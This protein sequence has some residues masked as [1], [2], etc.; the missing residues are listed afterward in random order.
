MS[1]DRRGFLA[2]SAALGL[3][4]A[5]PI[6]AAATP[7]PSRS[8]LRAVKVAA[9]A[10]FTADWGSLTAGY[11]A[12]DWFRDA[13]FG[14]WAHWA[15]PSV[16]GIGDDWYA[17]NMY[18]QG[19]PTYD[20][21][22]KTYGHPADTGFMQIQN[23]WRAEHWDPAEL[24]DL[25]K[26]AGARYFMA[27]AN[28]HDNL[29]CYASTH[30]PWNATRIGP[31]RDIVGTWAKLARERGLRFAVSNHSAHAW[32]WN[33]IAYDYDPVGPRRGQRYDAATLTPG[34]GR[35]Q[36]WDGL[37]PQQLYTGASMA[38]PD[39]IGSLAEAGAW[40]AATDGLW[41]E[42]VPPDPEYA[43]RWALRC[44][45]LIDR[46]DPDM[47]Y[48]DNHDL[49]LQQTG[50]DIAAYFLNR[51]M[52]RRGGRLEGVVTA[53]ET[54]PQRRMGL[55]DVVERGQKSF[56][57]PYPW[58]T[59]TC[60][61]NWFYGEQYLRDNSYKT[62]AKVLH[63]LCDVVSKNGNMML[64]VPIRGDGTIDA[65]E[66]EIVETIG[67][68]MR[69][70]GA[71]IYATRPW[72]I[73]AEGKGEA[74]GGAFS[75]GGNDTSYTARD[76]R[77]VT[78]GKALQALVLGWPDDGVARL[79]LL[80]RD[81]PV[82]RGAVRRVSLPGDGE[83]LAFTRTADALEVRLPAAARDPIGL[84]LVIEGPGLVD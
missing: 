40:H 9:P 30:Q 19:H 26:A 77:Y 76:I 61:G 83:S 41:N 7:S 57:D 44:R 14:I 67:A 5:A 59:E 38:M 2:G 51:N 80:G 1:V 69:K 35:G 72:R 27:L 10:R 8:A 73:H 28:H 24:L 58:Q 79:T 6:A 66:R 78:R 82:G 48:F 37:D 31:K 46:Y 62:P 39:G 64:S 4:Q 50:L 16:P 47:L 60:L 74:G 45:E 23:R 17:R 71:A 42:G 34:D 53:K 65:R 22:L 12:P 36:W 84:A 11:S 18:L 63:T 33:Q 32:H 15:A 55:V 29:D 75:E 43:R 81:N 54:P 20:H 70:N 13:K 49:P 52:A 21:H 68:W 56:I 25:Y 3:A